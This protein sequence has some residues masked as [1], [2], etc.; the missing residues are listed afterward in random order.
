MTRLLCCL[1]LT[2]ALL[3][4]EE[5]ETAVLVRVESDL[6]AEL[7]RVEL[8]IRDGRD[9]LTVDNFSFDSE[10]DKRYRVPFSFR[11]EPRKAADGSFV[12]KATGYRHEQYL[13]ET[14]L[15]VWF[16]EGATIERTL[17]LTAACVKLHCA[18]GE[19]CDPASSTCVL[20]PSAAAQVKP[21]AAD[22]GGERAG[23]GGA[24]GASGAG[25]AGAGGAGMAGAGGEGRVVQP[26]GTDCSCDDDDGRDAGAEDG[27]A[28]DTGTLTGK[29]ESARVTHDGR[30][31]IVF[32][33]VYGPGAMQ[34]LE[35]RG[36]S[37]RIASVTGDDP[38]G[39]SWPGAYI[40]SV[41]KLASDD[42]N[43]PKQVRAIRSLSVELDTN[44]GTVP[45]TYHAAH[46]LWF[47]ARSVPDDY[48]PSGGVLEVWYYVHTLHEPPA[49]RTASGVTIAG[50]EGTWDVW[51]GPCFEQPC[52][53]YVRTQPLAAFRGDLQP[54]LADA[55]GRSNSIPTSAY[56]S[57]VFAGFEI[58]NGAIGLA[59][60]EITT[61]V[62]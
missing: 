20:I 8:E 22:G 44:S 56:L 19:T 59:A 9:Q 10:L 55:L 25:E 50:V 36:S 28:E 57:A 52:I 13:G 48:F 34:T 38:D 54:F 35:Y 31:Y 62:R 40:G 58:H 15:R 12:V 27:G 33:N 51:Q 18:S 32:N 5:F 6:G 43:L 3:A 14:K 21:P 45:G 39:V 4:C 17:R 37:F 30:S 42:S 41:Y 47:S 29:S 24:A 61:I 7:T 53:W 26:T 2:S 11:V 23:E 49:E 60:N 46:A 16:S 1:W